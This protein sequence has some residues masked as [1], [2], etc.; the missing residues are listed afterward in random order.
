MMRELILCVLLVLCGFMLAVGL[1][2]M[3]IEENKDIKF[4]KSY[5]TKQEGEF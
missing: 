2:V 1:T 4:D 3:D 5:R